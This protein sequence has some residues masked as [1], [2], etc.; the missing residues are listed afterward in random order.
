MRDYDELTFG[1]VKSNLDIIEITK[2]VEI[3]GDLATSGLNV[4]VAQ[5][6][7]TREG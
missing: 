7:Q 5:R 6:D 1:N 3:K 2:R 4:Q